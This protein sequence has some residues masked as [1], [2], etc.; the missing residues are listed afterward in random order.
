MVV[1]SVVVDV[2]GGEVWEAVTAE[3]KTGVVFVVAATGLPH[4]AAAANVPSNKTPIIIV[5][6][7]CFMLSNFYSVVLLLYS[8]SYF[9]I[10]T[11]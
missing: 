4:P 5:S 1:V 11:D 7:R 8:M 3:V 10:T 6:I 9:E 2:I